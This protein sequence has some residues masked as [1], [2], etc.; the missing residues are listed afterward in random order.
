M[1]ARA[2]WVVAF[3]VV[4]SGCGGSD[5][6]EASAGSDTVASGVTPA[7]AAEALV[8]RWGSDRDA[9]YVVVWSLDGGYSAAQIIDAAPADRIRA[10]GTIVDADGTV[11]EAERE[12]EGLLNRVAG[13]ALGGGVVVAVGLPVEGLAA[14]LLAAEGP[15]DA[16]VNT[17]GLLSEV[18]EGGL[19]AWREKEALRRAQAEATSEDFDLDDTA[20]ITWLT[21]GLGARGYSA[22]QILQALLLGNW[23]VFRSDSLNY[24]WRVFSSKGD[25]I[26]PEYET[27][28]LLLELECAEEAER[29][30][31]EEAEETTAASSTT[32]TT[33]PA[34]TTTTT[35]TTEAPL[36]FP[37]TYDGGGSTTWSMSWWSSG[38][39]TVGGDTLKLTLKANGTLSGT[40]EGSAPS[41]Q[42]T[43]EQ[44]P[45][46]CGDQIFAEGPYEVTGRHTPPASGPS[47]TGDVF[48][49]VVGW[50][51]WNIQG[52]YTPSDMNFVSEI[53]Y[54]ATGYEG[55]APN[56]RV[57]RVVDYT[58][59]FS[60][61]G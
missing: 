61:E 45:W 9:F 6:G 34:T 43:T 1:G 40:Y 29:R 4:A 15:Q 2:W 10:D 59:L 36:A 47:Q 39:C 21:L 28:D 13:E 57:I 44:D 25:E 35:T 16:E 37:R 24:C 20:G 52:K 12:P 51:D 30:E 46:T 27:S 58:L 19:A 49:E 23:E 8:D 26:L 32:T 56:P 11:V 14:L 31:A 38:Q 53:Q 3:L 5:G 22:E 50:P 7:V 33:T 18:F 48:V 60:E 42:R 55:D 41:F 54:T 17:V